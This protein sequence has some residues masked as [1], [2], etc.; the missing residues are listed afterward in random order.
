MEKLSAYRGHLQEAWSTV[1]AYGEEV[2]AEPRIVAAIEKVGDTY[3]AGFGRIRA[4]IIEAGIEGDAYPLSLSEWRQRSGAAI[5]PIHEL[6]QVTGTVSRHLAQQQRADGIHGLAIATAILVATLAMGLLTLWIVICWVVR[7][8]DRI[9]AAMTKLAAGDETIPVPATE[10]HG[11][12]GEMA[13]A[14]ENFRAAAAARSAEIAAA[15][16]AL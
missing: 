16:Q 6:S 4:P 10:R 9:T 11:E 7:P 14:V 5:G 2:S 15:N 12:I 8:L 13:R 3:F 1:Q